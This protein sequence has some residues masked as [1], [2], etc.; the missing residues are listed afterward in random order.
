MK[1]ER[2]G[3][4]GGGSLWQTAIVDGGALGRKDKSRRE[5]RLEKEMGEKKKK[6]RNIYAC[7]CQKRCQVP[8]STF[9]LLLCNKFDG[10][11]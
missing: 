2:E 6:K 10:C 9:C 8:Q 11:T 7:M 1:K 4:R 3:E 5:E